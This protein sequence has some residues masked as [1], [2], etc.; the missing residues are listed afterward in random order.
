MSVR[1]EATNR[2]SLIRQCGTCGRKFQTTADSPFI[3]QMPK[4]GKRQATVYFCS[5]SCWRASY[6]HPGWWDGKAKERRKE[7]ER[8]RDNR[9]RNRR[10]Y[11]AN[12]EEI[13]ERR[14]A[15]WWAMSIEERRAEKQYYKEKRKLVEHGGI[16]SDDS[17]ETP[18]AE[19]VHCG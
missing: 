17:R 2:L 14:K 8:N 4:D 1:K 9:A 15:A 12:A 16:P 18:G 19:R 6:A 13:R 5:E 3:R 11:E 10:Y 7:K